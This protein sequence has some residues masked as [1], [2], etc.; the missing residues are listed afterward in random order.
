MLERV[1]RIGMDF[2]CELALI[3]DQLGKE[4]RVERLQTRRGK[5]LVDQSR[6]L[7]LAVV[8]QDDRLDIR[9]I[10][11]KLPVGLRLDDLGHTLRLG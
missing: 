3:L 2:A 9:C 1:V 4:L 5:L 8:S 7:L 10:Q 11:R 6:Q